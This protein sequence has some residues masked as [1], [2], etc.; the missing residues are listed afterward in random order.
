MRRQRGPVL[1]TA[2]VGWTLIR[3]AG[4]EIAAERE[5][6]L[7]WTPVLM[8][9]GIGSYFALPFEPDPAAGAAAGATLLVI[10]LVM[11]RRPAWFVGVCALLAVAAGFG[12]AQLRAA[13]VG[14]PNLLHSVGPVMVEGRVARVEP[15]PNGVRLTVDQVRFDPGVEAATPLRLRISITGAAGTGIQAGEGVALRAVLSPPP[16]PVAPGAFDYA[17]HLYFQGIGGV[18]YYVGGLRRSPRVE[19]EKGG[20]VPAF[21]IAGWRQA[22]AARVGAALPGDSG[23]VAAALMVGERGAI[24]KQALA[25]MRDSGLAH[26]LA[27]SGLHMGLVAGLLFVVLRAALALSE[28]LTLF[29]PIKKW[30]A[31]GA[32]LGAGVYL[33]LAG[34][35]V[36]TQRAFAMMFLMLAAILLDRS[37]VTMRPVAWAATAVLLLAPESL[38]SASFQMSFAAVVALIAAYQ[39]IWPKLM[40][41]RRDGGWLRQPLVYLTGVA[42]TTVIAGAATAPFALYHFNRIAAF[43]LAA[44]LIAVP[45]TALWVMPWALAALILMPV[46]AETIALVPLGLGV[47]GMLAIAHRVAGWSGA[48]SLLP[49]MPVAG[50]ILISLGGLWLCLWSRR[51]RWI[52]VVPML[53]GLASVGLARSPDILLTGDG[54]LVAVRGDNGALTLSSKTRSRFAGDL[55]LRRAGQAESPVWPQSGFSEDGRLSCDISGCIYRAGGHLVAL[56]KDPRALAEDCLRADVLIVLSPVAIGPCPSPRQIIDRA[57][58]DAGGGHAVYLRPD[59]GVELKTVRGERGDRPWVNQ[60]RRSD[61]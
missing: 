60:G 1:S 52:G 23:A 43:S 51:W 19:D 50:L 3:Q 8:G 38:L 18:G 12:A 30:A 35:T 44:N 57:D 20:W 24:S 21:A 15:R 47:E 55:W 13:W 40:A 32:L 58:L 17:R 37:A 25:D 53:V 26:L 10:A 56:V 28:R 6:W 39:G 34:A 4:G 49:A 5:R 7:L 42:L 22:I 14:G 36:P 29:Y 46:G 45:L 11:R 2:R 41:W 16:E 9:I 54:K 27:I 61:Q 48:V 33:M 59:G 31:A